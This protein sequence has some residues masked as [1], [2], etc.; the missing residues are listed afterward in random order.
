[1][2]NGV[3]MQK[4][5]CGPCLSEKEMKKRTEV[6]KKRF[7]EIATDRNIT[8]EHKRRFLKELLT[9]VHEDNVL[10]CLI[11]RAEDEGL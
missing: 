1:M 8:Q 11:A 9:A 6:L 10:D 4:D 7:F 5:A 3:P 2:L